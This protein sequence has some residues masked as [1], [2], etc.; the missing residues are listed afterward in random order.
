MILQ[1]APQTALTI[2]SSVCFQTLAV[3]GGEIATGP[4]MVHLSS[5]IW[6][7]FTGTL[8][9]LGRVLIHSHKNVQ[10]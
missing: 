1:S 2:L 8:Q 7:V 4:R 6:F 10:G 3:S 5:K 9:A